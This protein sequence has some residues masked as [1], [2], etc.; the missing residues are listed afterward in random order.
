MSKI[1]DGDYATLSEFSDALENARKSRMRTLKIQIIDSEGNV[2]YE[3]ERYCRS[4]GEALL[5]RD[6]L[7]I[8]GD[9]I[10]SLAHYMH[11]QKCE[12]IVKE[13]ELIKREIN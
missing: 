8:H 1:P 2:E 11:R 13:R 3:D 6:A 4:E 12:A 9:F 10:Y 7:T 5:L